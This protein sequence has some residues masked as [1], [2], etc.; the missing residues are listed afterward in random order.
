MTKKHKRPTAAREPLQGKRAVANEHLAGEYRLRSPVWKFRRHAK[1]GQ[2]A[3]LSLRE[4]DLPG[5]FNALSGYEQMRWAEIE[6]RPHCHAM[7]VSEC[8]EEVGRHLATQG[9]DFDELFQLSTGNKGRLFGVRL[10]HVFEIIFW[11]CDHKV[12]ETK[13]RNT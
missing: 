9:Y 6:A 3:W 5:V 12:Y 11:D 7:P 10:D 13:K 1:S 2:F 4:S 8:H